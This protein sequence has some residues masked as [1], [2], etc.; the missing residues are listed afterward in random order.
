MLNKMKKVI[1]TCKPSLDGKITM[2]GD[3]E[4]MWQNIFKCFAQDYLEVIPPGFIANLSNGVGDLFYDLILFQHHYIF[5]G[6]YKFLLF[7]HQF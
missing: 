3:E 5:E 1:E 6:F 4:D 2:S 7:Y